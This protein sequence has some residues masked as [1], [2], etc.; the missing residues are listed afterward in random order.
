M[1]GL[2]WYGAGSGKVFG[3]C[4]RSSTLLQVLQKQAENSVENGPKSASRGKHVFMVTSNEKS[5]ELDVTF[6]F[7]LSFLCDANQVTRTLIS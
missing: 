1:G 7:L 4:A 2:A 6:I 3:G 5:E